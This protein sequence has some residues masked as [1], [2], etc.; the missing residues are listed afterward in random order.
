MGA[1][2]LLEP[3]QSAFPWF[4]ACDGN[5]PGHIGWN[6]RRDGVNIEMHNLAVAGFLSWCG[7]IR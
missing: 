5:K 7:T 2:L 1:D 4:P 3:G 6:F